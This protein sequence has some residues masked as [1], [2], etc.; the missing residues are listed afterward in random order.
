MFQNNK[1]SSDVSML[2]LAADVGGTKTL[3]GLYHNMQCIREERYLNKDYQ[4]LEEII[5]KFLQNEKIEKACLAVAGPI[6]D[7]VCKMTN[8]SWVVSA[9]N[10]EEEFGI[11]KVMLI[12]DMVAHAYGINESTKTF[13][14]HQ[15]KKKNGSK[16]LIA[17][18]TGLGEV[19]IFFD[20]YSYIPVASEGGHVDFAPRDELEIEL[21]RYLKKEHEQVSYETV[22]SGIGMVNL[23]RF[24]IEQKGY[25]KASF[26]LEEASAEKICEQAKE[27]GCPTCR[28][29][30]SWFCSIYGAETANLTLKVMATGGV[31]IGGGIAPRIL[32]ELQEGGFLEAFFA[33]EGMK[34][35]LKEINIEIILNLNT[36]LN[37][38]FCCCYKK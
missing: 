3:I 13:T 23:Y 34:E 6:I 27:Y 33:K 4:N 17:A 2:F 19:P 32:D 10:I 22:L 35:L 9:K 8:L 24:L 5:K 20:G 15:G 11:K 38:S 31:Y 1:K 29:V 25:P 18:G 21:L 37:G 12:N 7:Q 14:L 26:S 30:L 16:A 28:K 36:A